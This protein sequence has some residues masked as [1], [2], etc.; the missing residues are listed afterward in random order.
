MKSIGRDAWLLDAISKN[1][2]KKQ[3]ESLEIGLDGL[4]FKKS[5]KE[6]NKDELLEVGE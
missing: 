4:I 3:F 5:L 2:F 1:H 6:K